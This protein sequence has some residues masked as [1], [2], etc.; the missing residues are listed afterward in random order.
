MK[1]FTLIQ[2][3]DASKNEK[4]K[5]ATSQSNKKDYDKQNNGMDKGDK[6]LKEE[7]PE[8]YSRIKRNARLWTSCK[9]QLVK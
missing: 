3:V 1:V 6:I 4:D 5:S 2:H 9:F 8:L 7:C